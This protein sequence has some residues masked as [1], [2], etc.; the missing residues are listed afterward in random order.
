MSTARSVFWLELERA[1][2]TLGRWLRRLGLRPADLIALRIP[3]RIDSLVHYLA[4]VEADLVATPLNYRVTSA[5]ST[6][7]WS[8]RYPRCPANGR[9]IAS[10]D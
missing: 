1:S 6:M 8:Q 10:C 5:R 9:R 4:C 7:P 2:A 3:S